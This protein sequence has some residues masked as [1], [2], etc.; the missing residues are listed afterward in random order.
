MDATVSPAPFLVLAHHRSGSN[1][2]ND[3]VQAHPRVD[4]INEPFSMHTPFFRHCDLEPWT[5]ADF[6]PRWLHRSLAPHEPLREFLCELRQH[7][8][9]SSARR[10]VGFKETGLFGKLEWLKAFVPSLR[11]VIVKRDPRAVV[12]SVL[13][14]G[15]MSLWRYGELVP[16]AFHALWPGYASQAGAAERDAELAAM[17]VAVRYRLA[18]QC[19]GLSETHAFWLEDFM[20]E[21]VPHLRRLC[22]FLGIDVHPLQSSFLAERQCVSR[23]GRYSSFRTRVDVNVGWRR[24]LEPRQVAAVDA[25]MAFAGV[26]TTHSSH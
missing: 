9:H 21:P 8:L 1:F 15:L 25:V 16:R 4:C 7:L 18:E 26:A 5:A 3:L 2:L 19:A 13:R 10:L 11:V 12:S 17:S 20:R 24:S 6:D 22:D 23:G 14:S